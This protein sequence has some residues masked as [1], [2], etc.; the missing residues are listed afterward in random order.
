MCYKICCYPQHMVIHPTQYGFCQ[1]HAD[2]AIMSCK[3][4]DLSGIK[5]PVVDDEADAHDLIK[6]ILLEYNARTFIAGTAEEALLLIEK[7][8]PDML[9][10]DIGMPDM[11]GFELLRRMRLL[12]QSSDKILPAIVLTAFARSEDWAKA[13]RAGYFRIDCFRQADSAFVYS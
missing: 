3:A 9:I 2:A 6:Q 8:K 13:L 4:V 5:V 7:E 1:S 12:E 10:S 11:D